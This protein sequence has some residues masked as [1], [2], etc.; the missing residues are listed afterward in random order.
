MGIRNKERERR[1]RKDRL[2]HRSG[3]AWIKDNCLVEVR[4]P[5]CTP[6]SKVDVVTADVLAYIFRRS[7]VHKRSFN[8]EQHWT[9]QHIISAFPL[10]GPMEKAQKLTHIVESLRC[11]VT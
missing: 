11:S 4:K 1:G 2:R 9:L 6:F 7:G 3:Q 5:E 8:L 10:L